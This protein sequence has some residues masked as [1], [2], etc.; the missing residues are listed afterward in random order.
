M[1]HMYEYSLDPL[2]GS[3]KINITLKFGNKQFIN[4]YTKLNNII[5]CKYSTVCLVK[6][7]RSRNKLFLCKI[8][9]TKIFNNREFT[10][11]N[12]IDSDKIIKIREIY[13]AHVDGEDKTFL[14]MDHIPG[15]M[16]LFDYV[17]NKDLRTENE[18]R[19]LIKGMCIALADC[20]RAGYCHGDVKMENFILTNPE[21]THIVLIDFGFAFL[22]T[23]DSAFYGGTRRYIAPEIVRERH[24]TRASDI[25]SIGIVIYYIITGTDY[26]IDNGIPKYEFSDDLYN[27]LSGVLQVDPE[28]RPTIDKLLEHPWFIDRH[29][30]SLTL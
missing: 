13:Q 30:K 8:V 18:L 27:L 16:D 28:A 17:N 5:D 1:K 22:D 25:W 2:T 14:I 21:T 24:G 12:S 11:P 15:S 4:K 3:R 9:S 20:H 23:D 19:P 26:N 10:I 29:P 7:K 6:R